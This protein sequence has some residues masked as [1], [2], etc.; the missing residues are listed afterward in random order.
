GLSSGDGGI[1]W[2]ATLTPTASVEDTTNLI[3]LDNTGMQD[4]AGNAGTGT[5]DSNNYAIDTLRPTAS[6]VVADTALAVGETS[7]VT[8]TFNEAV[9]G[10]TTADFTV[11]NG[12][13][14]GL[15]SGDGGI[16]W[17]ATL[18]PTASVEDST[19]LIVLDNT[20]MQDAA[21]NAGTGTTDSN[22]YAIDTL[23]P[24]ASIVVADTA[25]A[26][27][28][29]STV[30]ITFNEAVSGLTTADFTVAN[31]ALSGLSSGDGGITWTATLTPTAS[32]EDTTN[33]IVLDNTGVQD[34]AGNAG[35][36]TTDS[37]NYALDTLRPTATIVVADTFLTTGETTTV[38]ITFNEAVSGLTTADFTVA[39]GAL[40][41]LSS[42]D[43]GITWTATLTS[44]ANINAASNTIALANTG[45]L[46]AAGNSGIGS[47]DSNNYAIDSADPQVSIT[48]TD[49]N[50]TNSTSVRYTLTFSEAV[51]NVD[52]GDFS[53][54]TTG[55]ASGVIQSVVQLDAQTY[56]V[57]VSSLSGAGSL[58]LE[59]VA[60]SDISDAPGNLVSR[61][62][63]PAYTR[64]V[65]GGDPEFRVTP[66]PPPVIA[67][68][69]PLP[70][71]SSP[72]PPALLP[73]L[74]PPPL[75]EVP[76]LGGGIPPL[77]NIFLQDQALAPSF[78]AQVFS[79][80][81]G[82]GSGVG[83]LGFGG[84]DAGVFGSSTLSSVFDSL[85]PQE[86]AVDIFGNDKD[87]TGEIEEE[88]FLGVPS[89]G[90]QLD[91][92]R[93]SELQQIDQLARAFG[94]WAD[95]APVA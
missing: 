80:S 84:G 44:A 25:L 1:T 51:N 17:T 27:G 65:L 2:T 5:T 71:I 19:N 12:A 56:Q 93:H 32:V 43:G 73:P 8:I 83:F 33:L 52:V 15:S 90:Q 31:G 26:A 46:D 37:N 62:V 22:N 24:T 94:E 76:G 29:T 13:L 67:P 41:G 9:S 39:N 40:S 10:L 16:T 57:T 85:V 23:R 87:G 50:P 45:V 86:G 78:L 53:L 54:V 38:T 14:S 88:S 20:G 49:S 55:T 42:S 59:L 66:T 68:P 48:L 35:T 34:A 6:I 18:T 11:A 63:G 91:M 75:F 3:V 60:G 77:G 72:P 82:N 4:A 61:T 81:A 79:D 28:E 36:G 92:L 69:P 89:L 30:T 58:A 64:D 74:V 21:G 95:K 70:P 7:T 47:T